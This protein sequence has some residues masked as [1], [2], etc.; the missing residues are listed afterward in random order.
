MGYGAPAA[1][2][3]SLAHPDRQI[4]G[5]A[6]NGGFMMTGAHALA[7]AI[8]S[9]AKPVFIVCNNGIYGTIRMHQ[10]RDFP[11]RPSGTS[12]MN[13]DFV[14]LAESFGAFGVKVDHADAFASALNAA[15]KANRPALIEIKTDA[16]QLTPSAMP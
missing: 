6:G 10:D 1:V 4:I 11:N 3:A 15:L 16:R 5:F 13:P 9:G 8:Q 14:K 12:L 2:A 7:T